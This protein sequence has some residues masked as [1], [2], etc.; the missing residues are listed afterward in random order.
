MGLDLFL[1]QEHNSF[2]DSAKGK[3]MQADIYSVYRFDEEGNLY[4]GV[5]HATKESYKSLADELLSEGYHI[6]VVFDGDGNQVCTLE[7][8]P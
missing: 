6:I 3:V 5:N 2:I 1:F 8:Q 4:P 7:A